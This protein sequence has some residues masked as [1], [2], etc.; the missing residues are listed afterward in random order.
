MVGN[1]VAEDMVASTIGM[2]VFL[3]TDCLLNTHNLPIKNYPQGGFDDL[4]NFINK[5]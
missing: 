2:K 4:I 3:L 5:L 1:D